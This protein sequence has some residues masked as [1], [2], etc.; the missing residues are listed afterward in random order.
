M[1]TAVDFFYENIKSHF[2]HDGDLLEVINFSYAIAKEKER[3]QHGK[4]WNAG[5]DKLEECAVYA[6]AI[7]DFDEYEIK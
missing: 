4:T 3:E 1:K 7:N 2:E 6:R 5:I